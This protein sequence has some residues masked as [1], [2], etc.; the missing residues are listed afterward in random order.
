MGS[1]LKL[2]LSALAAS[3]RGSAFAALTGRMAVAALLGG[4]AVLLVAAAWGC[5]CAALWIALIPALGPAWAPLV[6]AG[7]CLAMAGI[8]AL[9][10]W[11]VMRRRRARPSD[12]LQVD[13][14][15]AEAGRVI[16]EHKGAALLAAALAGMLAASNGRKR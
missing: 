7:A 10:A 3:S 6:V 13:V 11:L 16:N 14:L 5:A 2:V 4:F 15:L 12:G 8:L 9:I 1:L